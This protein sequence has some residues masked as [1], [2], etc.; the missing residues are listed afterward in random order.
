MKRLRTN[1]RVVNNS[2]WIL[3]ERIM[4][5]GVSF[6]INIATV[7]YLQPEGFGA[8]NYCA[9]FVSVF[10]SIAA[11]GLEYVIIKEFV[12]NPDEEGTILGTALIM[13]I[14]AGIFSIISIQ[15]LV[16]VTKGFQPFYQVICIMVSLQLLFKISEL[17]DFW[18]QSKLQSKHVSIAKGLTYV[19][20]AAWKI[21]I[22]IAAK[23]EAWF[24][25]SYTLDA[26][27]MCIILFY[28]YMKERKQMCI[29]DR[30]N[31]D[32]ADYFFSRRSA[33]W[34]WATW[35]RCIDLFD[36]QYRFLDSPYALREMKYQTEALDEKIKT[37]KWHKS[38]GKAYFETII[39]NTKSTNHMLDIVPSRNL[40]SN[41]GVGAN[42]THGAASFKTVPNG[43]KQVFYKK[44][45]ELDFPL[46]H[47]PFV[48]EDV[49]YTKRF[50]R[51]LSEGHPMVK[52]W[53]GIE[54]GFKS[55][56]YSD[57]KEKAAKLKRL[58][59]TVKNV[60]HIFRK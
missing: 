36:T 21:Y 14:L 31:E 8:I 52:A 12:A 19:I 57:R 27:V 26:L 20:L 13:R 30:Y 25:F 35:K 55:F 60:L 23:T 48:I 16:G 6:F 28:I 50:C 41:I 34:G 46:R 38:T 9:S 1:N 24:A 45:Y 39:W 53:R 40:T 4:Q 58:P 37:C 47:P 2:M 17:L 51:I 33:I 32:Y 44:T 11:L 49:T 29:R 7:N 3:A 10:T 59:G 43:I 5:M 15:L 18:F 54:G 56:I 22:I 42:G